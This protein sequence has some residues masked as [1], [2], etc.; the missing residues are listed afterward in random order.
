MMAI[1]WTDPR[2][3]AGGIAVVAM[4]VIGIVLAVR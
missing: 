2:L 3:I 1:D 4:G